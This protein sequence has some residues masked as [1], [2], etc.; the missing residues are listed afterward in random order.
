MLDPLSQFTI[1]RL[2]GSTMTCG[3]GV[4]V[5]VSKDIKAVEISVLSYSP[6]IECVC[7]DILSD[8]YEKC[9]I[10]TIYRPG[11]STQN[12]RMVMHNIV[13][14]INDLCRTDMTCLIVG[15][16]NCN[17]IDWPNNCVL[18]DSLQKS[19]L[20]QCAILVFINLLLIQP[21]TKTLLTLS[22]VMIRY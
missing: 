16:L 6:P 5:F 9:R 19:F 12:D 10:L 21:G 17:S 4:C 18:H 8:V 14:C 11:G 22:Y 13:E 7:I 20:I 15:D 3:G 2:D 1:F